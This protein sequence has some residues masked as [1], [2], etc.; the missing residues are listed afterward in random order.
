MLPIQLKSSLRLEHSATLFPTSRRFSLLL[1]TDTC[2]ARSSGTIPRH[3][4]PD[5]KLHGSGL[6]LLDTYGLNLFLQ[7]R[8]VSSSSG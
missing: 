4:L 1:E 6:P 3:Y 2:L 7:T 8:F 5:R